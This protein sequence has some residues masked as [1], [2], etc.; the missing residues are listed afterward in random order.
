[1]SIDCVACA[2]EE[3]LSTVHKFISLSILISIISFECRQGVGRNNRRALRRMRR[4][5][6]APLIDTLQISFLPRNARKSRNGQANF[7]CFSWLKL[8]FF[9][10]RMVTHTEIC[11]PTQEHG[12]ENHG[13]VYAYIKSSCLHDTSKRDLPA[14]H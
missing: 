2:S 9:W 8:F 12:N 4:V 6:Y 11:I 13:A 3:Q 14:W 5:Q 7:S 10:F 1:M